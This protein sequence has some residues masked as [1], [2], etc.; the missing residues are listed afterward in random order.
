MRAYYIASFF[1]IFNIM[2]T[3]VSSF[4]FGSITGDEKV[5]GL[6]QNE[7]SVQ[8]DYS[9]SLFP[10]GD[11]ISALTKFTTVF[12]YVFVN[13]VLVMNTLNI[14]GVPTPIKE[15]FTAI[16]YISYIAAILAFLGRNPEG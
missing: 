12:G 3:L 16:C 6:L 4:G 10:F 1:L 9:P 11:W 13:G 7:S 14:I 15:I 2:L 8:A 5:M